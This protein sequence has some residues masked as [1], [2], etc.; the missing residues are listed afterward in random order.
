VKSAIID[1]EEERSRHG[2]LLGRLNVLHRL[3]S[4]LRGDMDASTKWVLLLGSPGVGKSAIV[5]G[6]L[7]HLPTGTPYHLIRRGIENWDRPEA[8][9]Q[10]LCARIE[11]LFP[12][13]ATS[14]PGAEPHLGELLRRVSKMCLVPYDRRLVLVIDGLD[15]AAADGVG[16]NPLPRFL[17]RIVPAGVV[18]LCASRPM[19]GHLDWVTSL[20]QVRTLDL[21]REEWTPSNVAV[22]REICIQRAHRI[23]PP[24][25]AEVLD[26][27]VQIAEG[28]ALHASRLCEWLDGQPP[29]RRTASEITQGLIDVFRRLWSDLHDLDGARGDLV[30]KGLVIACAAREA[31][32]AYLFGELLGAQSATVGDDLLRATRYLLREEKASWHE[33]RTGYRLFHEHVREVLVEKLGSVA[34]RAQHRR[35]TE[36]LAKWPPEGGGPEQRSYAI[37][38]AVA[39]RLEAGAV[40]A[41][42][43]LCTDTGYLEAKCRELDVL[44]VEREIEAVIGASEDESA[45]DLTA[46]L[47]ALRAESSRISTHSR[48]LPALLYNRL[49][50]TGWSAE[51]IESVLTFEPGSPPLRLKHGVRFGPTPLRTFR[52]H[53]KPIVA[54]ALT[55]DGLHA[56]SVSADRTLRFWALVSGDVLETMRGHEDELTGCALTPDGRTAISTSIDATARIWELA[57]GRCLGVLKNDDHGATACAVTRDGRHVYIGSDHG[58]LT[59]WDLLTRSRSAVLEGHGD[60]VTACIVTAKGHLITASR[61]GTVRVW[62]IDSG[63]RVHTLRVGEKACSSDAPG[64]EDEWITSVAALHD[65]EQILA[66]TGNGAIFCWDLTSG[67]LVQHF[68]LGQGRVDTLG[69]LHGGS[70]LLCGM[71]DGALAVWDLGAERRVL[72]IAAHTTALSSCAVTPDGR[73]VL[74]ASHDRTLRLWELGDAESLVSQDGHAGPI[75]A[76]AVTPDGN[77]AVSSS[78]DRSLRVWD[79]TTGECRVTLEGHADL[80]TACAISGDGRRVLSGARDGTVLVWTLDDGRAGAR[81]EIAAPHR[82]LVSG[83]AFLSE[84]RMITASHDGTLCMRSLTDLGDARVLDT[85]DAP[86]TAISL[87]RSEDRLLAICRDGTARIY[88]VK[89]GSL[90]S[91]LQGTTGTLLAGVLTPDGGR[92]ALT[93]SD[94]RI[95]IRDAR[96]Q[97]FMRKIPAHACRIFGCAVS[98]DGANVI[99]AA[100]DGTV[101]VFQ[102]ESARCLATHVGASWFRCVAAAGAVI[103]AGDEDGNLWMLVAGGNVRL[104]RRAKAERPLSGEELKRLLDALATVYCTAELARMVLRVVG[105]DAARVTIAGSAQEVWGSILDEASKQ[106]KVEDIARFALRQYPTNEDFLWATSLSQ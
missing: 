41:A 72:R 89:S 96:S 17:P 84:G 39:H 19:H 44:S 71:A 31:L 93:Y 86:V 38:H 42:Q 51:R 13:A 11:R 81:R 4:W 94:G 88:D 46:L 20:D 50:S 87:S 78:E 47:A 65:G 103:C 30:T 58:G 15:E 59:Q 8:V 102:I 66:S 29:S 70:H 2:Q 3:L 43:R 95:E 21:D 97:T 91:R 55:P 80:V 5:N 99:S 104:R 40:D 33:G 53:D 73:R 7:E 24:L 36:T 90:A 63:E 52:G 83:C 18:I 32:P 1:F 22:T 69:V 34:I 28:N 62:S 45:L 92:V 77:R 16:K 68:G 101:R 23:S 54:C 25:S 27:V 67:S 60:Y 79:V 57:E 61:D 64:S 49:R 37:R 85:C 105:L 14:E 26:A 74:S 82:A 12:E 9:V 35:F 48:S 100:E 98:P 56:L 10:N 6:L 106:Q 75:T 76:C